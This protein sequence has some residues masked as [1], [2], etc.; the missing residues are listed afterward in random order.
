MKVYSNLN[1]KTYSCR[2][3]YSLCLYLKFTSVFQNVITILKKELPK[4]SSH[5]K[6]TWIE[7]KGE[8]CLNIKWAKKIQIKSICLKFEEERI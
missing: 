2:K 1:A 6:F 7:S 3:I 4:S 8:K 5:I